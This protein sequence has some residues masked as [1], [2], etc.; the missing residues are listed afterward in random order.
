MSQSQPSSADDPSYSPTEVAEAMYQRDAA[1]QALGVRLIEV[2]LGRAVV[3]MT[4]RA[5]MV[6]GLDVCHGGLIFALA[7]T[8]MAFASNSFNERAVAVHADIDWLNPAR[9][10]AVLTATAEQ[11]IRRGRTAINDVT[12]IDETNTVIAVFRGRTRAI[13]GSH[14]PEA[15]S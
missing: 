6:N 7:D 5:D 15:G 11:Q 8:A 14:V 13:G 10:G 4:V 9:V 12:V 1:S 2:S 3:T